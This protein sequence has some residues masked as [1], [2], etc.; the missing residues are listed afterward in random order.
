ML[1]V[2]DRSEPLQ[3]APV[4]VAG[5]GHRDLRFEVLEEGKTFDRLRQLF[6]HQVCEGRADPL[7]LF[8]RYKV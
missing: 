7:D 8:L 5:G 2:E 1:K 3:L 6:R 4:P